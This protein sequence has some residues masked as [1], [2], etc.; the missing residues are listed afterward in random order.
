MM[1][2]LLAKI[3]TGFKAINDV[4]RHCFVPFWDKKWRGLP[5]P[6]QKNLINIDLPAPKFRRGGDF[7]AS[8]TCSYMPNNQY[9][10]RCSLGI[11]AWFLCFE[12]QPTDFEFNKPISKKAAPISKDFELFSKR[13]MK[14]KQLLSAVYP[15]QTLAEGFLSKI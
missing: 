11:K 14:T 10:V 2:K 13:F 6:W 5:P 9:Y 3:V 8:K 7:N 4:Y 1:E 15:H 12:M